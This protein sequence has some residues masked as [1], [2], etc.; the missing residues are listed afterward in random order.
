MTLVRRAQ[1]RP[2]EKGDPGAE[3]PQTRRPKRRGLLYRLVR[4]VVLVYLGAAIMLLFFQSRLMYQPSKELERTPGESGME[5]KDV[6]L[7]TSDGLKLHG[8]YVPAPKRKGVFLFFHGN[9]GNIS[10]RVESV[11]I[12]NRLGYDVFI[13]DYRGYG[14][15]EGKPTEDGTYRDAGAAW[16]YLTE[17]RGIPPREIVI[18]GRSLGGAVAVELAARCEPA[19]VIVESS[20]TSAPDLAASTF[21]FFPVRWLCRFRYDSLE[22]IASLRCPLLVIHSPDDDLIPFEN[23]Q[24]LFDAASE[25]K[26]FLT[27]EGGHNEGFLVSSDVYFRGMEEFLDKYVP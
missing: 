14:R 27:I 18:F 26:Q 16:R 15:S 17:Q 21:P 4:I 9:A 2:P 5:F 11:Y 22:K 6:F 23:G 10:H 3:A 19:A 7:T 24:K 20:F 1:A 12:F 8:W 13:I 25:P